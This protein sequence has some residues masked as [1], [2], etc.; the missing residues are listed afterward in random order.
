MN[1]E[2]MFES[3]RFHLVASLFIAIAAL[4]VYS[5]TFNASFHFDDTPNIVENYKIRNFN[6]WFDIMRE[7]RGVAMLTFPINYA[8]GGLNV[9]GYH[10]VNLAIHITNG[11]L[12]YFLIFLTLGGIE[13]LEQKAKKIA[14]YTALVFVVHPVQTQ[15]VTYIVQRMEALA[16]LFMLV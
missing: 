2:K 1:I 8:I 5:N 6:N 12:V 16:S 7:Q 10:V 14:I 15:A 4:L 9:T 11:I 3:Q 13:G